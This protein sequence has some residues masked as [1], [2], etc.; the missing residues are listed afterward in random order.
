MIDNDTNTQSGYSQ[1][2]SVILDHKAI[3]D[4]EAEQEGKALD[5][6]NLL[7]PHKQV[8][9][10]P[11]HRQGHKQNFPYVRRKHMTTE[12][13]TKEQ[14]FTR[15]ANMRVNKA[16]KSV[17]LIGNLSSGQYGYTDEDV[18]KI[19]AALFNCVEQTMAQFNKAAIAKPLFS[20]TN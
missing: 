12:T 9:L 2:C 13:E 7:R 8:N 20:L 10:S 3:I 17:S 5:Q 16:I 6:L 18:Q 14:K 15:L 11:K 4:Q 19:E 1:L